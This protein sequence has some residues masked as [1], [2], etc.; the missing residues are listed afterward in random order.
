V[1]KNGS[2]TD[3]M[4]CRRMPHEK[5]LGQEASLVKRQ[6][7]GSIFRGQGILHYNKRSATAWQ[8]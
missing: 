3:L 7:R 6:R 4:H 5:A 1:N 8:C 2:C